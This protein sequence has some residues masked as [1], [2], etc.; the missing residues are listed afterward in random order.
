MRSFLWEMFLT[1]RLFMDFFIYK[2]DRKLDLSSPFMQTDELMLS[3][4]SLL[5][6]LLLYVGFVSFE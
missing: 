5:S 3:L 6:L 1:L 2:V 4:L